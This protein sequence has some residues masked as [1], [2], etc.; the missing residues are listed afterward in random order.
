MKKKE[1]KGFKN[2]EEASAMFII[3]TNSTTYTG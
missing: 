3:H 2:Y 1:D